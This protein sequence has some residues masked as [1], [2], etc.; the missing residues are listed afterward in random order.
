MFKSAFA[1]TLRVLSSKKMPLLTRTKDPLRSS[2]LA[3]HFVLPSGSTFIV[4]P[5]PSVL[6]ATI[7][8]PSTSSQSTIHEQEHRL[9]LSRPSKAGQA[10]AQDPNASKKVLSAQEIEQ[11]QALRRSDPAR[12][13]RSRLARKFGLASPTVVGL[14]GWGDGPE[15]RRAEKDRKLA[16]EHK[17]TTRE[18]K[19]GWK[20]T[21]A[22][23]ER[24]RRRTMW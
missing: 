20:K 21:I 3:E 24:R 12:W 17:R 8:I 1:P 10:S 16:L 14:L 5:P 18:L 13:T 6:P 9:P 22:V 11:L 7:A 19:W 2:A 15:G 4:R 23:E